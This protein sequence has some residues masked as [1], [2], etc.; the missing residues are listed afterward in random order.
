M[1]RE[2]KAASGFLSKMSNYF[3]GAGLNLVRAAPPPEYAT[4]P[5]R[6]SGGSVI[7]KKADALVNE[8]M[9]NKK[10]Y[11]DHTEHMLSMPDDAIV[12]ALN[13]AKQVAA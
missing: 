7:D 9:R 13:I 3:D 5:E 2:N 4:R 12:Q 6:A 11:S 1:A 10:L 8:T